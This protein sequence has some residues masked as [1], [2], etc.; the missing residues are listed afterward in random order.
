MPIM[1]PVSKTKNVWKVP[2]G[3]E[4][5]TI[6]LDDKAKEEDVQKAAVAEYK[7]KKQQES[8]QAK[9][10]GKEGSTQPTYSPQ[11]GLD[12][13]SKAIMPFQYPEGDQTPVGRKA[14]GY[15]LD[16]LNIATLPF[17]PEATAAIGIPKMLAALGLGTLAGTGASVAGASPE[18]S[19]LTGT[20]AGAAT[21]LSPKVAAGTVGAF[22]GAAGTLVNPA[23]YLRTLPGWIANRLGAPH[24]ASGLLGAGSAVAPEMYAGMRAEA[25]GEPWV[26][27]GL[28]RVFGTDRVTPP[29]VSPQLPPPSQFQ[30]QPTYTG[31]A[32]QLEI[33]NMSPRIIDLEPTYTP[34]PAAEST[35]A[36]EYSVPAAKP[37][38]SSTPERTQTISLAS[39]QR[40]AK[41][42]KM[43]VEQVI[44]DYLKAGYELQRPSSSGR[45]GRYGLPKK[46][47]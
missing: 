22:K 1:A 6:Y 11:Y 5:V 13:P 16:A 4:E 2:V 25:A 7:R 15:G 9:L 20:V 36:A 32:R 8:N 28:S 17:A 43:P 26:L 31:R 3:G 42:L 35:P 45:S 23:S 33:G 38:E 18:M 39:A 40:A 30:G 24:W 44:Q 27:P 41:E 46:K 12:P 10:F 19:G 14:L 47:Q 21:G 34:P 37:A 29:D